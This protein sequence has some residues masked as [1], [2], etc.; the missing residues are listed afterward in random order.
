MTL[1]DEILPFHEF[2]NYL[3][4]ITRVRQILDTPEYYISGG[5]SAIVEKLLNLYNKIGPHQFIE[6]D[7]EFWRIIDNNEDLDNPIIHELILLLHEYKIIQCQI[8]WLMEKF[9][10]RIN[11]VKINDT[12]L[13]TNE[14]LDYLNISRG[15]MYKL[16]NE[17]YITCGCKLGKSGEWRFPVSLL[18]EDM[19][20]WKELANEEIRRSLELDK[21]FIA[22][23]VD[24]DK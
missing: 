20:R 6:Q 10:E 1:E 4:W 14:L 17:G 9:N 12:M 2:Y 23:G 3:I 19:E 13:T 11:R 5:H 21:Q 7:H 22:K 16:I 15:T 24:Y 8:E 18:K